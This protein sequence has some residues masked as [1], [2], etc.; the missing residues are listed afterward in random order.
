MASPATTPMISPDGDVGDIPTDQ[1][2]K[3]VQ[4]GFKIGVELQTD[5]GK[6]G[7]VP[8][9][10]AHDA[11][12][13][14]KFH[15]PPPKIQQPVTPQSSGLDKTLGALAPQKVQQQKATNTQADFPGFEGSM[16]SGDQGKANATSIVGAGTGVALTAGAA[17]PAVIPHTIEGVKA[18]TA[19]AAKN[20]VAAFAAYNI[21]KELIPGAKKAIGLV[22]AAPGE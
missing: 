3:A 16:A 7:V 17:L 22:K 4:G 20:P 9:D 2:D 10:K 15:L 18:L 5:D 1:V 11:I 8:M 21:I 19:W 14:G 12:K 13:T 6:T